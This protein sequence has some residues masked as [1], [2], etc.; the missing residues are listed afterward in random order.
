MRTGKAVGD[1]AGQR[2]GHLR[3]S[4]L[5]VRVLAMYGC[6]GPLEVGLY[7]CRDPRKAQ[8]LVPGGN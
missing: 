5:L 2:W 4:E 1:L 6:K 7:H 8:G 3:G